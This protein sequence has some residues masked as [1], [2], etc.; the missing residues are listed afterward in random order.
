MKRTSK[1]VY[2]ATAIILFSLVLLLLPA[3]ANTE[4]TVQLLDGETVVAEKV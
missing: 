1:N 2:F 3:C 4:H